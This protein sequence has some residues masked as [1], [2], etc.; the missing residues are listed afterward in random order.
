MVIDQMAFATIDA[1]WRSAK[2]LS[3]TCSTFSLL[4]ALV[5]A[6]V[7]TSPQIVQ[8]HPQQDRRQFEPQ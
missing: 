8:C 6:F 5:A 1:I 3:R 7:S 2:V 4:A